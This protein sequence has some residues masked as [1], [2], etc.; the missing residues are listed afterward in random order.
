MKIVRSWFTQVEMLPLPSNVLTALA[1]F[2]SM[3]HEV[4]NWLVTSLPKYDAGVISC[5]FGVVVVVATVVV[6][7]AAVVVRAPVVAETAGS[8]PT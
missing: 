5:P 2:E 6:V 1:E 8:S 7:G 3:D 4:A